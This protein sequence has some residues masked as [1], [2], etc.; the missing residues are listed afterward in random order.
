MKKSTIIALISIL[1][2]IVIS[3][4]AFFTIGPKSFYYENGRGSIGFLFSDYDDDDYIHYNKNDFL[5]NSEGSTINNFSKINL[6][7]N[8]SSIELIGTENEENKIEVS[9][10]NDS[11]IYYSIKNDTLKVYDISNRHHKNY[12][13]ANII[14]IYIPKDRIIKSLYS[15]LNIG[16]LS[17]NDLEFGNLELENDLGNININNSNINNSDISLNLGELNAK[18][19]I[20]TNLELDN[21]MGSI[22]INGQIIGRNNISV[23]MGEIILNLNQNKDDTYIIAENN[24]GNISIDGKDYS[25]SENIDINKAGT[26]VIELEANMGNIELNFK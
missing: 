16:Y 14:K 13:N 20:F 8:N 12:K 18:N 26:N 6:D 15:D 25:S 21:E 2:G 23:D 17:I 4:I 22:N 7:L 1:A 5:L 9:Y 10:K 24:M 3:L 11:K 19:T